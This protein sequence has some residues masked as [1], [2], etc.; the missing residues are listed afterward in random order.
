MLQPVRSDRREHCGSV[1]RHCPDV[2]HT[3]RNEAAM[4]ADVVGHSDAHAVS[5]RFVGE[6]MKICHCAHR[7]L[8]VVLDN[9]IETI[10][11]SQR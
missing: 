1:D 7:D 11:I 2:D 3:T 5:K 4:D 10:C 9:G 8:E 6:Q